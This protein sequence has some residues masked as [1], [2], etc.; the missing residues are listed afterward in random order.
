MLDNSGIFAFDINF[1]NN[2]RSSLLE[3]FVKYNSD[4][5]HYYY[6][7]VDDKQE[8]TFAKGDDGVWIDMKVGKTDLAETVG[9]IIERELSIEHRFHSHAG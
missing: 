1:P 3:V 5:T 9:G 7:V 4:G 2:G 6:C 8:Y